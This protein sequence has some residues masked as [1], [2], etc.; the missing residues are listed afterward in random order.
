MK[1]IKHFAFVTTAILLFSACRKESLPAISTTRIQ[2]LTEKPW[3]LTSYGY[4]RNNNGLIDA[5]EEEI[6][7]C[8]QLNEQIYQSGGTGL[9]ISTCG[10]T[11]V[12]HFQWSLIN[13]ETQLDYLYGIVAIKTLTKDVMLLTVPNNIPPVMMYVYKH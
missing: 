7:A 2:L 12:N 8:E 9:A 6:T 10:G 13:N 1:Q 5:T 4:D 11:T 3:K